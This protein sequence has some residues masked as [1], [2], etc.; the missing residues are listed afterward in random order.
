MFS[1]TE[2]KHSKRHTACHP[3]LQ[4]PTQN[5]MEKLPVDNS[6][7]CL[8]VSMSSPLTKKREKQLQK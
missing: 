4:K 8:R 6:D 7:F 5:P 1:L 2:N 3:V